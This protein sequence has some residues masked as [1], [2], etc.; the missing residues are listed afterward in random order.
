MIIIKRR[1]WPESWSVLWD[2]YKLSYKPWSKSGSESKSKSWSKPG[3][4]YK[5]RSWSVSGVRLWPRS[6]SLG[7]ISRRSR[8]L[9][10]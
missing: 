4:G 10:S 5:S 8:V 3:S 6:V 2:A 9:R 7:S 1:S